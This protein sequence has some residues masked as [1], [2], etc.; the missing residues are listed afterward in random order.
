[1]EK[2]LLKQRYNFAEITPYKDHSKLS[3]KPKDVLGST[4]SFSDED[5]IFSE[6]SQTKLKKGRGLSFSLDNRSDR[7]RK[8]TKFFYS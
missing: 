5:D 2:E 8:N 6:F 1:M 7:R 4:T 3:E